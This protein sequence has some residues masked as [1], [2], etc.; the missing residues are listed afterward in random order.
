MRAVQVS[1]LT[2]TTFTMGVDNSVAATPFLDSNDARSNISVH[3]G[4][5]APT[6]A[7]TDD[8][9]VPC[10]AD[11]PH[12]PPLFFCRYHGMTETLVE[13]PFRAK[14]E[15]VTMPGTS[16]NLAARILLD[17]PLPPSAEAMRAAQY[18]GD[19]T[20]FALNLSVSHF[21]AERPNALE[22]AF[23]GVPGG[24]VLTF[25]GFFKPPSSP[26]PSLPPSSPPP[27]PPPPSPPPPQSPPES[28]LIEGINGVTPSSCQAYYESGTTV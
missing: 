21:A 11:S 15:L 25:I 12:R 2:P 7:H 26:P 3:L 16:V 10:V 14:A 23:R 6:C 8:A 4:N 28:P 19:G 9:R 5:V 20:P 1:G 17:C 27:P 13:G 24:D 22:L 18:A